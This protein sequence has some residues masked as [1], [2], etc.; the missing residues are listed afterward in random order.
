MKRFKKDGHTNHYMY[1]AFTK[2]LSRCNNP[3]DGDYAHYGARGIKVC[4]RWDGDY[5]FQNFL[6]DMGERPKDMTLDRIDNDGDYSPE[7]CRWAVRSTQAQNTR[8]HKTNIT[9]YRGIGWCKAAAK[10]RVRISVD[11]KQIYCGVFDD[12]AE[13][14]RC[15][16]EAER[17]YWQPV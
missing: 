14:I 13:A 10:W 9:G 6:E 15:R 5:G 17:K 8:N 12:I 11:N 2:M 4:P 16:K 1:R 3:N 7:N